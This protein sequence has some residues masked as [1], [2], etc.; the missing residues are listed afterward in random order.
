MLLYLAQKHALLLVQ[1]IFS[2]ITAALKKNKVHRELWA[3]ESSIFIQLFKKFHCS[4]I[5]KIQNAPGCI[6]LW[7]IWLGTE[8]VPSS[9]TP[10][11]NL[12]SDNSIFYSNSNVVAKFISTLQSE[13][14]LQLSLNS[15]F[16]FE[17]LKLYDPLSF[18]RGL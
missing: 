10:S 18:S 13:K 5:L 15:L 11:S 8:I 16:S 4:E 14:Y 1:E 12:N 7:L 2:C 3:Q 6:C 9:L 17:G